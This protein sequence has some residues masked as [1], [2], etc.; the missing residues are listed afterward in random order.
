MEE[1]KELT[2]SEIQ[3]KKEQDDFEKDWDRFSDKEI[4]YHEYLFELEK[5]GSED[6]RFT[7]PVAQQV[8]FYGYTYENKDG[9]Y[10]VPKD[11]EGQQPI[12]VYVYENNN[13]IVFQKQFQFKY[14]GHFQGN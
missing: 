1:E 6:F 8:T 2:P 13:R 4:S 7:I 11:I 5:A 3:S 9:V 10:S 12:W 14:F